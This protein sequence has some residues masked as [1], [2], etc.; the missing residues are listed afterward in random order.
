M[1]KSRFAR[2]FRA[3]NAILLV[4][5]SIA[6]SA[7]TSSSA[8]TPDLSRQVTFNIAPQKLSSALIEFSHQAKIQVV[9][10]DNL[11]DRTCGGL[12]GTYSIGAALTQLTA[13]SDFTFRAVNE[14]SV[15][16]QRIANTPP[17]TSSSSPLVLAPAGSK[18]SHRACQADLQARLKIR[19]R[20]AR[21]PKAATS[22]RSSLPPRSAMS[23]CRTYRCPSLQSAPPC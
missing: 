21:R 7:Q 10:A 2:F 23:G 19:F 3:L 20:T 14:S 11:G 17:P 1:S 18:I 6:T 15:T 12:V 5:F 22:M 8:Q 16:I 13:N 9:I 4:G